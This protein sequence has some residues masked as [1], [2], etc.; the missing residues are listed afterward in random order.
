MSSYLNAFLDTGG[1][2]E[3]LGALA[4]NVSVTYS[5]NYASDALAINDSGEVVGFGEN[6]S[7]GDDAFLYSDDTLTD[8][9][10]LLPP[11][12]G[13]T[14]TE[15]TGINDSD[16]IVG[17]GIHNGEQRAFL[18]NLGPASYVVTNTND[19][20]PGSLRAVITAVDADP[21]ANGN[22]AITFA[23]NISGG[24]ISLQSPLPALTRNQV[25]ITGA[26]TIDGTSAGGDGLDISGSQD[27][28]QNLTIKSFGGAGISIAGS[29]DTITGCQLTGD[30][31]GI[32]VTASA[33]A[34][35][36][37]GTVSGAGNVITGNQNAGIDLN[38]VQGTIVQGNWIGTDS[39]GDISLGNGADG[40]TIENGASANVIGLM[41]NDSTTPANQ[42]PT[43]NVIANNGRNG[44]SVL[45][46]TGDAIRG[47]VIYGNGGLAIGLGAGTTPRPNTLDFSAGDPNEDANYPGLS[48]VGPVTY[49]TLV[50]YPNQAY[51]FDF[52]LVSANS[53]TY[54]KSMKLTSDIDGTAYQQ[55][56]S[57]TFNLPAPPGEFLTVTATDSNGDTSEMLPEAGNS[58]IGLMAVPDQTITP[59]INDLDPTLRSAVQQFEANVTSATGIMPTITSAY[60]PTDYQALFF[61]LRTKFLQ[62]LCYP[63]IT[64]V[65]GAGSPRLVVDSSDP[66]VNAL[67]NQVN[68]LIAAHGI[69][70]RKSDHTPAVNPPQSSLHSVLNAQGQPAALAVDIAFPNNT[71]KGFITPANFNQYI[72]VNPE[73]EPLLV[74]KPS[75]GGNAGHYEL[76]QATLSAEIVVHSPVALLIT[77]PMG[78][79]L[80]YDP[81]TGQFIDEIN[82]LA[83]DS[84]QGTEP[85]IFTIPP[86]SVVPGSYQ[87]SGVGTGSGPYLITLSI[88]GEDSS[89]S[90]LDENIASGVTSPGAA[91]APISP[92]DLDVTTIASMTSQTPS[93]AYGVGE[94]INVTV[95]FFA[96]VTLAG[97]DLT[98]PLNDGGTVTIA[99]FSDSATASGTYTV[100]AGD[101]TPELDTS[102]PLILA[103][104]ATLTDA[105]GNEAAL[106]IPFGASLSYSSN[107]LID[108]TP[109]TSTVAP[110][111]PTETATSF[112]VSWSGQDN[113]GGSGIAFYN[114]YVSDDGGP[115]TPFLL[116]TT[117]TSA[118]FTGQFGHTYSYYSE[119]TDNVGNVEAPPG[120]PEAQTTVV[121]ALTAV[122]PA[123]PNPRNTPVSTIDLAFNE[124]VNLSTFTDFDLTLAVNG[125]PNLITSAVTV[126]PVSGSTY[127]IGGLAGLTTTSGQY[128]LTVNAKGIAD[129]SGNLGSNSLSTSWLMDTTPP[130]SH[131]I[132][133]LGT[134]QTS[135]T[136]PVSVTFSDPTGP[137]VAPASGVSSVALYDSVNN[138]PFSLYQTLTL[139]PTASGTVT[140]SFTG[141]DRNLYA[142][143][144]IAE[145]AAGN[146]EGKSSVAIEASTSV[147]D[148]NAPVTHILASNPSYSW[149]PFPSS[150]F[151]ALTPSSYSN[152]VF[153]LDWAGADPDQ[154]TGTPAGS[155]ARVNVYVVIDGGT[156]TQIGQLNGGAPNGNGVGSRGE[157]GGA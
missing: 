18:L 114:I 117:E 54:L 128:T 21:I 135:D 83:T 3:D 131:V 119:A 46:G 123:T 108:T 80:G 45:G 35:T 96:P 120:A 32:V 64:Q 141:Q 92:I 79:R 37:G 10:T 61:E 151:S 99:P 149:G 146:I 97:G 27:T 13:W 157:L 109:P 91:I 12:S 140:F 116:D 66:S 102:S 73:G 16:Q 124:P 126:M 137:V 38:G 14:L 122:G 59:N 143:H 67:A 26:I 156:P 74:L 43:A 105:D 121:M 20:G 40:I 82:P 23:S 53:C 133:A 110:L 87:F 75:E 36:I 81:T 85:E 129:L 2:L 34:N 44:V 125:G 29:N 6:S 50:D 107:F 63:G 72:P 70:P 25:S 150:E 48:I 152:G 130:A 1:G 155:I 49:L 154:N 104:G 106:A 9:N 52:Y 142:F 98:I 84:G 94:P 58:S 145:D 112:T 118:T 57:S 95:N 5:V 101:N 113:P 69:N 132:N 93:G 47:N 90:L 127:Q 77:D 88:F 51:T 148:L 115:Y 22:D 15:A 89:Q 111:L 153:T 31:N 11:D 28:V 86:G 7:G 144:S 33:T 30:Q 41:P 42:N 8:L 103:A 56:S 19:S 4:S 100:A 138:G 55:L 136:F 134:S 139:T 60:R 76:N 17:Y 68:S 147:P 71:T 65:P 24:T 62:L 78:R 39:S